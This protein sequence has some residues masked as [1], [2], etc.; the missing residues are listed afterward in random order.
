MAEVKI[1]IEGYAREE[2]GIELVSCTTT[3]IKDSGLKIVVDP[4]MNKPMLI[5]AFEKEG[6]TFD[7][8]DYVVLTHTDT[9]HMLLA[10]L[11]KNS[12]VIDAWSIY[13]F[14]GKIIEHRDEIPKTTI[15]LLK[16]PGHNPS[17]ISIIVNTKEKGTI[18]IAGDIFWWWDKEEQKTNYESL[19]NK[20]DP[21]AKDVD[22]LK[23][24]RKKILKIADFIIPGHGKMFRVKK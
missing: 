12:K 22:S 18:V 14:D 7:D 9:D 13:T 16:T 3:L 1:L 17:H 21:F 15:K 11:F 24:S 20:D 6:L 8:I 23:K 2:K 19:I 5:E 4:G 10:A